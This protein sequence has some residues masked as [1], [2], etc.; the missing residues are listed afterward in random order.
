MKKKKNRLDMIEKQKWED[1][2]LEKD[3]IKRVSR[4]KIKDQ[5]TKNLKEN[6]NFKKK[7]KKKKKIKKQNQKEKDN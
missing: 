1:E 3:K 4:L 6:W 2:R 7:E 5:R